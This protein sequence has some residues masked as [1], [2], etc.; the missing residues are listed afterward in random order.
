MATEAL[1]ANLER[2]AVDVTIPPEHLVLL[3]V[4]AHLRG[5][6][7]DTERLLEEIHHTYVGWAQTLP[8]LHRR[9][10]AD[11]FHCNRHQRGPEGIAVFCDLYAKAVAEATPPALRRDAVRSWLTYLEKVVRRSDDRLR[12]NL[13]PVVESLARIEVAVA[14]SDDLAGE[15]SPGLRRLA[16]LLADDPDVPAD[17]R[18]RALRLLA[19]TL[20]RVYSRW[21]AGDDP[22]AW[23][24]ELRPGEAG[25]RLPDPIARISHTRLARLRERVRAILRGDD[26]PT[27]LL[28]FPDHATIVRAQLDAAD[29]LDDAAS[30]WQS[31]RDRSTWMCRLLNLELAAPVHERA[32]WSLARSCRTIVTGADAGEIERFVR[33]VFSTVRASEPGCPGAALDLVHR[34]GQAML[35]TG[36]PEG[37]DLVID[38][39]LAL[40]FHR[41]GFSG[42]TGEWAVRVDPNHLRNI[43]A[44]L[45]VVE[46][47]PWAARRLLA[48]LVVHLHLGGVFVADTDLFQR[49]V[50]RLL[51]ADIA[52]VYRQVRHLLRLFPVYF[53]DIG[54][55]GALRSVST[56]L[57]E[58]RER[59]DPLCHFL[60]KQSHVDSTPVLVTVVEE[61]ARF[62]AT[63]EA[64]P[65][66]RYLPGEVLDRLDVADYEGV[67]R[68][69]SRL[70]EAVGGLDPLFALP[71]EEVRSRLEALDDEPTLDR[72]QVGLLLELRHHL[73]RKYALDHTDLLDRLRD[74]HLFPRE[75]LDALEEDLEEGRYL[76]AL[77]RLV[78]ILETLEEGI[79]SPGPTEAFEDIYHKRHIAAGIPSMYGRYREERFEALGLSFR[80]ESLA[81]SLFDRLVT[82]AVTPSGDADPRLIAA[83]LRFL[84]RALRVEGYEPKGLALSIA[85]LDEALDTPGV[86]LPEY[87]D[88]FRAVS[89]S[90]RSIVRTQL[91]GTYGEVFEAVARRMIETGDLPVQEQSADEAI[92]RAAETFLRDL[93]AEGLALQRL[94][95]LAE[96]VLHLLTVRN[97]SRP[98]TTPVPLEPD[99]CV[100]TIAPDAEAVGGTVRLGNKGYMLTRMARLG[101]PVPP[102][103]ILTTDLY[104]SIDP[105]QP[106]LPEAIAERVRRQLA[107]L[108]RRAGARFGDPSRPLLLSVRGGAPVSMPGMLDTFLNVGITPEIAEGLAAVRGS[109]WAAWDAYRRFLQFWGMSHGIHRDRFDR[110][111]SEAKHRHGVPKKALLPAERMRELAFRYRDLLLDHGVT[112]T[113]SPFEQLV[114]A[115]ELV[116]G[117]WRAAK[118]RLYRAEMQ[119]ADG[120]GTAVIIQAMVFG[121]LDPRSGTGVVMTRDPHHGGDAFELYGDFII[122]GQGDD[123]VS[124]L[125]ETFPVSARQR[126]DP[127]PPRTLET[128]FPAVY[129]ALERWC[130]VLV[131]EQGLP[132]QEV[133]FTFE[134]DRPED[135]YILQ[136]REAVEEERTEMTTFVPSPQLRRSEVAAGVGVGGGAFSGRVAYDIAGIVGVRRLHPGDPVL[137]VRPDTVPDDI[138]LLFQAD[139]LL[140]AVGGATSHAAVVA[141][142]LGKPCVVGCRSLK[143]REDVGAIE[144][145]GHSVRPGQFLSINGSDGKVY[146]GKHPVATIPIREPIW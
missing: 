59:R 71:P 54:A 127:P 77:D 53:N 89:R 13:P 33:D 14:A 73:A 74:T 86:S 111:M 102:G 139:G 28:A 25:D 24:R 9:A 140:T 116:L 108:E 120:W 133:E 105:G 4:A 15:A 16:R 41:P 109:A 124:G 103:F 65:L 129:A 132:H 18:D 96:K 121:N 31:V 123:V 22:A 70:T 3:D 125:V 85:M 55:E 44:Y 119:V 26:D 131:E 47:D 5:V 104:R 63:G 68:V 23:Y 114:R 95:T 27:S 91:L 67:R 21:L 110:L 78:G 46:V 76:P 145:G 58:N 69:L 117:S 1:R 32:L 80:V 11:L 43:R 138:H 122:Q 51:A 101:L 49:D 99:R 118:A 93:I 126:P 98:P 128:A 134:S 12:A 6:R 146:L 107:D 94:D 19:A 38:E 35:E 42:F 40:D 29:A 30:P 66:R 45:G 17:V 113:P 137:L 2:T 141:T 87:L 115:I 39:I 112:I 50:S 92:L 61:V 82:E 130:R 8:E 37:I 60:R 79:L 10:M 20:E 57:D 90:V 143:L 34:L 84:E 75:R 97:G 72:E 7:E 52:P 142:R 136:S 83:L 106:R 100:A 64:T 36:H 81:G 56:R 48:A 135:L 144:V 62:W 88:I